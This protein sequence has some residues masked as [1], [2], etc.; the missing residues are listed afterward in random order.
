MKLF[1][2]RLKDEN[3]FFLLNFSEE[4]KVKYLYGIDPLWNVILN[5]I[6]RKKS[7]EKLKLPR[8]KNLSLRESQK[9][10]TELKFTKFSS[11]I[12][13]SAFVFLL[14]RFVVDQLIK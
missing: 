6:D 12:I 2:P 14:L 7:H 11:Q 1:Y 4:A 5:R 8:N 3:S 9:G 13:S 10:M